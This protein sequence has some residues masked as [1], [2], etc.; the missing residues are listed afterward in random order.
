MFGNCDIR[1]A[2]FAFLGALVLGAFGGYGTAAAGVDVEVGFSIGVSDYDYLNDYGDWVRVSPYGRVWRPWVRDDWGPFQQGHWVWTNHGW[3][4]ISYEPFGWLVCHYGYWDWSP[5]WGWFWIPGTR[6]YPARVQWY[7]MGDYYAW[8]PMPPPH[9]YWPDPWDRW[10]V[11]V[12]FVVG[13]HD[14]LDDHVYDRRV[15]RPIWREVPR[16][17]FVKRPPA[18]GHVEKAVRR[19]IPRVQYERERVD[20]RPEAVRRPPRPSQSVSAEFKRVTIPE[21]EKSRVEKE[22]ERVKREVLTPRPAEKRERQQAP[23]RSI[24]RQQ[25]RRQTPERAAPQRETRQK[26]GESKKTRRR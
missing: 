24:D 10:H 2:A 23:E 6:W 16:R 26:G 13:A 19:T 14:F 22:T 17:D 21:P 4:W 25:E 18:I 8:A 7:M 9:V 15:T 3:T 5:R 12:W 20:I 1:T 11:N